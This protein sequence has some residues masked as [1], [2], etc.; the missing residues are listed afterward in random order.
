MSIKRIKL[1]LCIFI[2]F[3]SF[4]LM[5]HNI[6]ALTKDYNYFAFY[7]NTPQS[8][9]FISSG[10]TSYNYLRTN[11]HA[12]QIMALALDNI[13]S[14]PNNSNYLT[15]SA[16]FNFVTFTDNNSPNYLPSSSEIPELYNVTVNGDTVPFSN[17]SVDVYVTDWVGD[18]FDVGF[19]SNLRTFTYNFSCVIPNIPSTINSLTLAAKYYSLPLF[20]S[21]SG[22]FN[23]FFEYD[24]NNFAQIEFSNDINSDFEPVVEE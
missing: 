11:I 19:N 8:Q 17:S 20:T 9:T 14:V 6:S 5:S 21:Y 10:Q 4:F 1:F 22:G 7:Y 18:P 2:P 3:F 12:V 23:S 24:V 13:G 16:K 15:V